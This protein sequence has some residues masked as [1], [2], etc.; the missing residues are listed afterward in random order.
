MLMLY[1]Q[2]F[3]L[4]VL[5]MRLFL[6]RPFS[7]IGSVIFLVNHDS[8]SCAIIITFNINSNAHISSDMTYLCWCNSSAEY[9]STWQKNSLHIFTVYIRSARHTFHMSLSRS[10]RLRHE[11]D[12]CQSYLDDMW[13]PP[14]GAVAEQ[15]ATPTLWNPSSVLSVSHYAPAFIFSPFSFDFLFLSFLIYMSLSFFLSLWSDYFVFCLCF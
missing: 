9:L 11:A 14:G 12:T 5:C 8:Q 3:R 15:R 4:V 2:C 1:A 10:A 13:V 7:A 6:I